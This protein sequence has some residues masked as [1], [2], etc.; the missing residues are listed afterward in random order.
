MAGRREKT[1]ER[2]ERED[3]G[4]RAGELTQ[5]SDFQV[6]GLPVQQSADETTE[7]FSQTHEGT[8][9]VGHFTG[10]DV[11]RVRNE[12]SGECQLHLLSD[13]YPGLVLRF[14]G[15]GPRRP[16]AVRTAVTPWSAPFRTRRGPHP[17]R[18]RCGWRRPDRLR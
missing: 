6:S 1:F 2:T 14:E 3:L 18:V 10:R 17:A 15:V 5:V 13:C 8:N 9:G 16:T 4:P 7:N 11:D 12:I